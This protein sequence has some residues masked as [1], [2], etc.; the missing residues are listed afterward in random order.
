MSILLS[1]T[2]SICLLFISSAVSAQNY[3]DHWTNPAKNG[4]GWTITHHNSASAAGDIFAVWYTYDSAGKNIWYVIPGGAF[5]NANCIFTGTAYKTRGPAYNL[6]TFDSSR[7]SVTAAGTA[8]FNFCPTNVPAGT[9][10]FNYSI[11][12]VNGTEPIT[13]LT[14]GTDTQKWPTGSDNTD[15]WW[16][17]AESGWGL[18]ITQRGTTADSIFAA[19]YTYDTDGRPSFIVMPGGTWSGSCFSGKLYTTTGPYFGGTFDPALVKANEVGS[20]T[21]CFTGVSAARFTYT[22][23]GASRTVPIVR[24]RFA[25]DPARSWTTARSLEVDDN[26][27]YESL[28]RIDDSDSVMSVFLKTNGTR[29]VLYAARGTPNPAGVAPTWTPPQVIDARGSTVFNNMMTTNYYF[30]LAVSP[31][32]NALVI[33][34]NREPCTATTYSTTGTCNIM[35]ST[36]FIAATN[37][38]DSPIIVGSFPGR[39]PILQINDRG[40]IA[41]LALG[42]IRSGTNRFDARLAVSTMPGNSSIYSQNIFDVSTLDNALLGMDANG[43]MTMAAE[44]SQNSTTDIVVYRGTLSGGFGAQRVL[45]TR[46]AAATLLGLTVGRFGQQAV[47]W[48]QNNG[49]TNTFFA[50]T[51]A[52]GNADWNVTDLRPTEFGGAFSLVAT[53]LGEIYFIDRSNGFR[54]KWLNGAWETTLRLPANARTSGGYNCAVARNS[55]FLCIEN[56]RGRW[57]SYDAARNIATQ[58]VVDA[59]LRVGTGYILGVDVINRST[60]LSNPML[61]INGTGAATMINQ[62]DV[63]PTAAA[64]AGDGRNVYNFWGLFLK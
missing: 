44:A 39:E 27:V 53:D 61:S 45:D 13:R 48:T 54:H 51:S 40:D 24:Q 34:F 26:R 18:N 55:D 22:V 9:I 19:W 2:I 36:R 8:S 17:P 16:S 1:F 42:W 50:A 63:L 35:Y 56:S 15:L 37:T 64:P 46:G 57:L 3:S 28:S 4:Q 7:V 31:N 10:I 12:G 41:I 11:D 14:F 43:N 6:P 30:N 58:T 60:E 25:D 5:S 23:N 21:I 20:G 59:N 49:S 47:A 32:G 62:Y 29:L 33:W 52:S 38:W